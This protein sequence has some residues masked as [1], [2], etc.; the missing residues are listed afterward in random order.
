MDD[1]D[2]SIIC[3]SCVQLPLISKPDCSKTCIRVFAGV[4][5]EGGAT[6]GAGSGGGTTFGVGLE[7]EAVAVDVSF[8]VGVVGSES[9]LAVGKGGVLSTEDGLLPAS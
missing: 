1:N 8:S 4:V 5:R 2:L 9:G 3:K 7:D 6:S